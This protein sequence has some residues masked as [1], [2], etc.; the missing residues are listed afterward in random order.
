M[1]WRKD[2]RQ[3]LWERNQI[4][5]AEISHE[6]LCCDVPTITKCILCTV[7]ESD[8]KNRAEADKAIRNFQ[9]HGGKSRN[10]CGTNKINDLHNQTTAERAL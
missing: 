4:R 2:E 5:F 1:F 7:A 8:C 3:G 6:Y 10:G 9:T